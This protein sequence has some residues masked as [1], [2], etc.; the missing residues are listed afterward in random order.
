[1]TWARQ[2]LAWL[3]TGDRTWRNMSLTVVGIGE[4]LGGTL[5]TA[6]EALLEALKLNEQQGNIIYARATRGM[7]SGVILEQG[8][9][10]HTV[11]RWLA[12]I[13]RSGE[14]LPLLQQRREQLLQARLLLA[15]G[16]T[17]AAVEKLEDLCSSAVQT[18][19]SY[20]KLQVQVVLALAYSQQGSHTKAREQLRDLLTLTHSEGYLRLFLDEG[21]ELFDLLRGLLPHLRQNVLLAYARRLLNAFTQGNNASIP[22]TT[23]CECVS[24]SLSSH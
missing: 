23:S 16:E 18:G 3:P 24:R 9:L 12:S 10:R 6:R 15:Q 13:E 8:E 5:N 1:M 17:S 19:H 2:S 4:L 11:E 21:E 22:R 14:V 7:L 20:F